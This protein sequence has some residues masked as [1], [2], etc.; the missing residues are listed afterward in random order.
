MV[1]KSRNIQVALAIVCILILYLLFPSHN[2]TNDAF[3]S[4]SQLKYK[5]NLFEPHHLLHNA[6]IYILSY[7]FHQLFPKIDHLALAKIWNSIFSCLTLCVLYAVLKLLNPK[8]ENSLLYIVLVAFSFG[9]WRFSTESEFYIVPILFSLLGSLFFLKYLIKNK[10]SYIFLS[11]FFAAFACVF[12]QI[13]FFWWIAL[14]I[15]LLFYTRKIIVLLLYG[16]PALIVPL[17]YTLVVYYLE[18]FASFSNVLHFI[19][20][21][22]ATGIAPIEFGVRNFFF[23][24]VAI[25]RTFFQIFPTI[26]ILLKK[27]ILFYIPILCL[28]VFLV[29]ILKQHSRKNL[30]IKEKKP[31]RFLLFARIHFLILVFYLAFALF[32]MGN[33]EFMVTVPYIVAMLF[34]IFYEI[35]KKSLLAAISLMLIWNLTY[36]IIPLFAYQ[37]TDAHQMTKLIKEQPNAIFIVRNYDTR[38]IF[39]YKYGI[40][41]YDKIIPDDQIKKKDID[42]LL[43]R[44]I[45]VYTNSIDAPKVI[46]RRTFSNI[47][48]E[49]GL[50]DN[51]RHTKID[52]FPTFYGYYYLNKLD[53]KE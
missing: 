35:P 45:L 13:H 2:S 27:S 8:K 18:G 21:A 22:Y 34:F 28:L 17:S 40:N 32:S 16:L 51:Y 50:F 5:W 38:N 9:V 42:S 23:F 15:G 29:F 12:H 6:F 30:M 46:N 11:G 20:Y 53:L 47:T 4:A 39:D 33:S 14:L 49:E 43:Y 10:I 26:L 48:I 3:Y 24:A 25:C 52:S 41:N 44:N 1:A 31:I 37:M 36:G 19:F 7:P